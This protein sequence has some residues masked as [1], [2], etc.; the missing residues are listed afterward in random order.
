MLNN[1]LILDANVVLVYVPKV[2]IVCSKIPCIQLHR[3]LLKHYYE[4]VIK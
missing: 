3:S 1:P 2:M 4:N